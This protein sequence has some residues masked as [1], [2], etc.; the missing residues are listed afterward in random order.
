MQMAPRSAG[1]FMAP[2]CADSSLSEKSWDRGGDAFFGPPIQPLTSYEVLSR[3]GSAEA[4]K[5]G[6]A[7]KEGSA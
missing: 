4:P 5:P 3:S 1:Y 6:V 2:L 7:P